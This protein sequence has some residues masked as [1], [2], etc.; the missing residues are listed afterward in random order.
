MAIIRIINEHTNLVRHS[1]NKSEFKK[2]LLRKMANYVN[3]IE[4][5]V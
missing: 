4:D 5:Y 1:N 2:Y 3:T